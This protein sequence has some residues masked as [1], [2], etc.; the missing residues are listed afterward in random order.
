MNKN[1]LVVGITF[2]FLGLAIQPSIATVQPENIN[3]EYVDI[4]I[5]I[6]RLP[7]TK[8]HTLQIPKEQAEALEKYF[9]NI[10]KKLE[11]VETRG[12]AKTILND[13]VIEL[14]RYGL[15]NGL[16]VKNVQRLVSKTYLNL[17]FSKLIEKYYIGEKKE[18]DTFNLFCLVSTQVEGLNLCASLRFYLF[19]DYILRDWLEFFNLT[20][21]QIDAIQ[22]MSGLVYL[23]FPFRLFCTAFVFN[24][25]PLDMDARVLRYFSIGLGGIK[26]GGEWTIMIGFSGLYI[27]MYY[28]DLYWYFGSTLLV[29]Y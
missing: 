7:Y 22:Q 19:T 15:L 14:D 18:N 29:A 27:T 12:E 11:Q 20:W 3:E 24:Q 25:E 9:N 13:V 23:L 1:F 2:L 8:P 21:E 4:T 16:S 10:N 6:C 26:K 28:K 5:N 17:I